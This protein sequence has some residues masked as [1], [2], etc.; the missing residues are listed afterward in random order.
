MVRKAL[1]N[2]VN[3]LKVQFD[4]AEEWYGMVLKNCDKALIINA[5]NASDAGLQ[6]G[7]VL[8]VYN[9]QYEWEGKTCE[10]TLLSS[11]KVPKLVAVAVVESVGNT[12]SQAKII[13][14]EN[15]R[16]KP[17]ARVYWRKPVQQNKK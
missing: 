17:G 16:V 12:V 13:Q 4:K 5:G 14:Q 8:E 3:D 2:G 15:E 9:T 10:S 11:M 1:D 7:D 6:V